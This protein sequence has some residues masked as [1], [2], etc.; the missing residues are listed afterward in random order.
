[1][2]TGAAGGRTDWRSACGRAGAR[3][4]IRTLYS[5]RAARRASRAFA[6]CF[7]ACVL[8]TVVC[9]FCVAVGCAV[10]VFVDPVMVCIL[11]AVLFP[12]HSVLCSVLSSVITVMFAI[13]CCPALFC[14]VLLC[15]VC[16]VMSCSAYLLSIL[17]CLGLICYGCFVLVCS[18][19]SCYGV[20]R[21]SPFC[22]FL[23]SV[24]VCV[25]H[26]VGPCV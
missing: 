16:S 6:T 25:V 18:A 13:E 15:V 19:M 20:L 22:S 8:L 2:A 14:S 23:F 9:L 1:M 4:I 26:D 21:A 5:E 10:L 12:P 24:L 3:T 11:H 17:A 7:A